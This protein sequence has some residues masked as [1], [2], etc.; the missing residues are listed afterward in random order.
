MSRFRATMATA[1]SESRTAFVRHECRDRALHAEL[2]NSDLVQGNGVWTGKENQFCHLIDCGANPQ[3]ATPLNTVTTCD[4][5][6]LDASCNITC[7][8]GIVSCSLL[9]AFGSSREPQASHCL[10]RRRV[11]ARAR[12]AGPVSMTASARALCLPRRSLMRAQRS[13]PVIRGLSLCRRLTTLGNRRLVE[14]TA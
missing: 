13:Q 5:H 1:L 8:P 9:H 7:T 14:M 6:L 2:N 3:P 12:R 4:G 11:C 10:A